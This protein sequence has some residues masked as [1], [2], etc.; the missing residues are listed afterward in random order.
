M[1]SKFQLG[2]SNTIS[3]KDLS[4]Y[5]LI[6]GRIGGKTISS[7]KPTLTATVCQSVLPMPV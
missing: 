4:L 6:N 3:W 7:Q 2:W 1:N 5:F